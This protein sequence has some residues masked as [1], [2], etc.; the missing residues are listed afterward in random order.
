MT[1]ESN[2]TVSGNPN[3]REHD[4]TTVSASYEQEQLDWAKALGLTPDQLQRELDM[5]NV[6]IPP[7][8][9]PV[10]CPHG[11]NTWFG[12]ECGDCE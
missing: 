2:G 9:I 4:E 12:H 3:D 6:G 5:G 8:V 1:F 7:G 10:R 11:V